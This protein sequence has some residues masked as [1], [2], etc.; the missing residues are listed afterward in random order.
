LIGGIVQPL[1]GG[2]PVVLMPPIAFLQRPVRW[3]QAISRYQATTS[4]G[5]NFAYDL[6]LRRIPPDERAN[7]DLSSWRVAFNG[8]E[9]VRAETLARFGDAF[10]GCGFRR[11]AFY[12]CYGLAEATLLVAGGDAAASPAVRAFDAAALAGNRVAAAGG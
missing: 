2:F 11:T 1:Y 4:G 8:A 3:L 7:L 6:C 5:P 12:P 9:P 10:G